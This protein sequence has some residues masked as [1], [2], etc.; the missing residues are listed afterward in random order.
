MRAERNE[1]S[2]DGHYVIRGLKWSASVVV[3]LAILWNASIWAGDTRYITKS[4]FQV[5][6]IAQEA[7]VQRAATALRKGMLEDKIFEL[8]LVPDDRKTDVQR[9][10]ANRAKTQLQDVQTQLIKSD[11][12]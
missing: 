7:A 2:G 8:D 9:A 11:K 12:P 5:F 3:A 10:M 1:R 4:E 6:V